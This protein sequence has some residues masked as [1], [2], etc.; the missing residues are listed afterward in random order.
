MFNNFEIRS[1]FSKSVCLALD[2]SANSYVA[3]KKISADKFFDEDFKKICHEITLIKNLQHAN[4]IEIYSVFVKDFDLCVVYPF[5][6]FGSCKE[7]IK[8][9]FFH[10]FPEKIACLILQ[11]V[12]IGLEYLHSRAIIHR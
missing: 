10:G 4:I 7:A 1:N 8:N 2:K 11:D 3:L 5:F 9:F 6:C 12:L